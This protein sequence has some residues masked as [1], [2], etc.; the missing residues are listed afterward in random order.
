MRFE[1][2]ALI[3]SAPVAIATSACGS[4]PVRTAPDTIDAINTT[5]TTDTGDPPAANDARADGSAP[6]LAITTFCEIF[7]ARL[8]DAIAPCA[9]DT[10]S[11][12]RAT[13]TA[14]CEMGLSS[15]IGGVALGAIDF[16]PVDAARC[17][18]DTASFAASCALPTARAQPLPCATYLVDPAM[19]G[20]ACSTFGRGLR[21]ADGA[22][23]CRREDGTC[24]ALA[25]EGACDSRLACADDRVCVGGT[26]L[27]HRYLTL[28]IPASTRPQP[29]HR[30]GRP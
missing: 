9:C 25:H 20:T 4:D 15:L 2:Y 5:D 3:L 8:C 22:G 12:C 16:R 6:T 7:A 11:P 18:D 14:R 1:L 27:P 21:C 29:T 30:Y 10:A 23:Y 28:V 17:V 26:C 24:T 13:Q 19:I